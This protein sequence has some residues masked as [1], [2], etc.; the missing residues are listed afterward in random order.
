MLT[1]LGLETI[2]YQNLKVL[3]AFL[4]QNLTSLAVN[5]ANFDFVLL[6]NLGVDGEDTEE[7]S[8]WLGVNLLPKGVDLLVG[9]LRVLFSDAGLLRFK[10]SWKKQKFYQLFMF[11]WWRDNS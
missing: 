9:V 7:L 6:D 5:K 11:I 1:H 8:F 10:F 3:R 2:I 4:F